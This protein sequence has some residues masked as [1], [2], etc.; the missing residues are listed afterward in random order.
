MTRDE[1]KVFAKR[2]GA[3]SSIRDIGDGQKKMAWRFGN[4]ELERF[5]LMMRA[6]ERKRWRRQIA[7]LHDAMSMMSDDPTGIKS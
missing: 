2:A 1:I 4:V 7:M 3:R 5:A 6:E